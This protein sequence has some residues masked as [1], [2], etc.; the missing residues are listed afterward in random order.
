[1]PYGSFTLR[2]NTNSIK[3]AISLLRAEVRQGLG[4]IAI[5]LFGNSLVVD[6]LIVN[7]FFRS[8][9]GTMVTLR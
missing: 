9:S 3:L 8:R 5:G 6:L 7:V 2:Q 1:M 4:Y